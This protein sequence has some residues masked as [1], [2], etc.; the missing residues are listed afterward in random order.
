MNNSRTIEPL[1]IICFT[2]LFPGFYF[3]NFALGQGVAAPFLS[4]YFAP[5]A[6]C[7][8][9]LIIRRWSRPGIMCT[10]NKATA[11]FFFILFLTLVR[12]AVDYSSQ[13]SLEENSF[14]IW[15]AQGALYMAL[16]YF[17]ALFVSLPSK[18]QIPL[19]A[20]LVLM[21]VCAYT[22]Y[23]V[24]GRF[25]F[26]NSQYNNHISSYQGTGR[27]ILVSAF[28]AFA[29][30]KSFYARA[31]VFYVAVLALFFNGSRSEF[32][33]FVTSSLALETLQYHFRALRFIFPIA[34]ACLAIY[35][36]G[37]G[38]SSRILALV[39]SPDSSA[40]LIARGEYTAI[41]WDSISQ[42]P[43]V[44]APGDYV[45]KHGIGGYAHNLLSAWVN[46]G[47]LG[48]L[49]YIAALWAIARKLLSTR[50]AHGLSAQWSMTF[51]L[52]ATTVIGFVFAKNHGFMLFGLAVGF[53]AKP[54]D[55]T[56]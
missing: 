40:S 24:S 26:P 16:F 18:Y 28:M 41:A 1:G 36:I 46:L 5:V 50:Q 10:V 3:Y 9:L 12:S 44:G 31:F 45:A 56:G 13:N 7:L 34:F 6:L 51:L 49:S 39:I 32:V 42:S 30:S 14:S 55:E 19:I 22:T 23:S 33:F 37:G 4:G 53:A 35:L 11:F 17:V 47:L 38:Q 54:F 2:F 27:S 20:T 48:I 29:L 43:I 15:L 25:E 8:F 21:C 52:F